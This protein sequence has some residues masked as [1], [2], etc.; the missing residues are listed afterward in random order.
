MFDGYSVTLDL[1]A[2]PGG[3]EIVLEPE[4][5]VSLV[6]F[7]KQCHAPREPGTVMSTDGYHEGG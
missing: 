6:K 2:Q 7:W 5:Y 1:R 3:A 4:V